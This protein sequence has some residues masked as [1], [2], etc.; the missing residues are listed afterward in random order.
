M[1]IVASF[2]WLCVCVWVVYMYI[3]I[4]TFAT[5]CVRISSCAR[6]SVLAAETFKFR[7]KCCTCPRRCFSTILQWV[8][9]L[10]VW[11]C[12]CVCLL[13]WVC[14]G[15]LISVI[16]LLRFNKATPRR[17]RAGRLRRIARRNSSHSQESRS[18]VP[19]PSYNKATYWH[20][21]QPQPDIKS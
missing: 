2:V 21:W 19:W 3:P 8:L 20:N 6:W 16:A 11:V 10:H 13:F 18:S 17:R 5:V 7:Y 12:V 1:K 14:V 4:S 15:A 9:H